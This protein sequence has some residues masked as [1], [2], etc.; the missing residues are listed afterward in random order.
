MDFFPP[1]RYTDIMLSSY[2]HGLAIKPGKPT[3]LGIIDGKP[4][5]GVP[6]YPV[7]AY[8]VMEKV[9]KEV[10]SK[11]LSINAQTRDVV[12]AIMTKR[13]VSSLKNEEFIRVALGD[14]E[15]KLVATPM[16]R[17]AAAVM[18]M[19]KAD[20]IVDVDR[21]SEG[22]EAG[23]E[24]DVELY[25]PLDEIK[26]KLVIIGSHDV[27]IDIIGDTLP[28]SSAHVGSMGGILAI[29][30]NSAHIAPI[31]LLDKDTGEYNVPFVKKYFEE[32]PLNL[33]RSS[34]VK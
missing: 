28:V 31:H 18:S 26:K 15:G 9:V 24:V 8:I 14:V 7:S 3:I 10:I 25:R 34:D 23:E 1:L 21:N 4:V 16:D 30:A 2:T 13:V 6:G 29:K 17:G 11:M 32:E 12:K 22:I 27:V 5:I 20:G 19:V 33:T